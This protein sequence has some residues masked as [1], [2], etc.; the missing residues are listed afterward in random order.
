M[1]KSCLIFLF[2]LILTCSAFAANPQVMVL[3]L[4]YDKGNI[5]LLNST[6]KYGFYPDKRYQPEDG[7]TME[8]HSFDNKK[9]YDFSFKAPNIEYR[10]GSDES[11]EM[12]GG[13]IV[14]D[15]ISFSLVIPY[16]QEMKSF[17]IYTPEGKVAGK[18]TFERKPMNTGWIITLAILVIALLFMAFYLKHRFMHKK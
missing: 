16:Y 3:N 6:V 17:T 13:I 11:K 18:I 15:R 10:E 14:H 2:F 8:I 9:L 1:T 7:Y 5:T 12:H 4:F